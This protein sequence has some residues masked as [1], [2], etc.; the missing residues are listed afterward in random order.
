MENNI[1][2][3]NIIIFAKTVEKLLLNSANGKPVTLT[4]K[5]PDTY[6]KDN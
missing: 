4:E 3:N 5:I 6:N 1:F 2:Y